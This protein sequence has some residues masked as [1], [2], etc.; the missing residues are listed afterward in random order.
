MCSGIA[1]YFE[2]DPVIIR[3]VMAVLFLFAGIGLLAYLI[4][5]AVIPE[6]RSREELYNKTGSNPMTFHDIT[7]NVENELQD[8]KKRGE[9]MSRDL[10]DFF[11]KKR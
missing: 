6:A 1:H 3:L 4:C 11:S 7:R 5:W 8:L 10:K 2:I 9:Q